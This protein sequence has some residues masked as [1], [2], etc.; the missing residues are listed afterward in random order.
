MFFKALLFLLVLSIYQCSGIKV[1][2][3]DDNKASIE[4][5][6]GS[7]VHLNSNSKLE[8]HKT[9]DEGER[10]VK[11]FGEG[12]FEIL[13]DPENPFIVATEAM[14]R[15]QTNGGS[16]NLKLSEK[17][18]KLNI[19]SGEISFI[20]TKGQEP[21]KLTKGQEL[22]VT[23]KTGVRRIRNLATTNFTFWRDNVLAFNATP[24]R[25]VMDDIKN[26]FGVQF[27]SSSRE[28]LDCIYSNRFENPTLQT[29]L[30]ALTA[31]FGMQFN[32][33]RGKYILV[34]GGGCSVEEI[35]N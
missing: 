23:R 11:F 24:L 12:F 17:T 35:E 15:I 22:V 9:M 10:L 3:T 14:E 6:E 29:T 27:S 2:Q 34:E 33:E 7:K 30:D 13:H 25:M 5:V 18:L 20:W 32:Q 21:V 1:E 31:E 8:H 19:M 28:L 16:F 26:T 4:L